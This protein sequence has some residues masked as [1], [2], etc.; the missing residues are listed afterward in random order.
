MFLGRCLLRGKWQ[1]IVANEGSKASGFKMCPDMPFI[2]QDPTTPQN[3]FW[4]V[5]E[6]IE[7]MHAR[8]ESADTDYRPEMDREFK[9]VAHYYLL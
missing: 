9:D 3:Y 8:D 5:F 1:E 2:T 6:E 4:D 7:Y